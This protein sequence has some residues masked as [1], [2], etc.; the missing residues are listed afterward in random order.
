[1]PD[2]LHL[3][4]LGLYTFAV[5]IYSRGCSIFMKVFGVFAVA[6]GVNENVG[7]E[8]MLLYHTCAPASDKDE[9]EAKSP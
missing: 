2:A 8:A 7:G 4:I 3:S 5:T 9:D 6:L 1:M